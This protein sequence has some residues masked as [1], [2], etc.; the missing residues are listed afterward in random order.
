[1]GKIENKKVGGDRDGSK[2]V[3]FEEKQSSSALVQI[4]NTEQNNQLRRSYE[5]WC[6]YVFTIYTYL[7]LLKLMHY[8]NTYLLVTQEYVHLLYARVVYNTEVN[9][10]I[11]HMVSTTFSFLSTHLECWI[12]L[13]L[14]CQCLSYLLVVSRDILGAS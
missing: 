11:K 14:S 1:M 6:K 5:C 8:F 3:I 2:N 13:V 4:Q 12:R 9:T 7:S 10:L